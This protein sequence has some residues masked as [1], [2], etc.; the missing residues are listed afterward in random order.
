[1]K[2]CFNFFGGCE[3]QNKNLTCDVRQYLKTNTKFLFGDDQGKKLAFIKDIFTQILQAFSFVH[4]NNVVLRDF[5]DD[6]ILIRRRFDPKNGEKSIFE[7]QLCD[8]GMSKKKPDFL[9][10]SNLG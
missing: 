5:K 8:F 9:Q 10:D 2:I 6:N 4:E 3:Y 7:I 1:M